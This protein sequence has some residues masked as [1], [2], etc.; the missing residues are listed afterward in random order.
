MDNQIISNP[1]EPPAPVITPDVPDKSLDAGKKKL[2][3]VVKTIESEN[4]ILYDEE[5]LLRL[6]LTLTIHT[7]AATETPCKSVM[8]QVRSIPPRA[9]CE[10]AMEAK[11]GKVVET[12]VASSVSK[13]D[14][15]RFQSDWMDLW[16]PELT[17]L[18]ACG[19]ECDL[20]DS[21]ELLRRKY[22][23]Y[24]VKSRKGSRSRAKSK[25]KSAQV[26]ILPTLTYTRTSK[27]GSKTPRKL[28]LPSRRRSMS[29]NPSRRDSTTTWSQ[30]SMARSMRRRRAMKTPPPRKTKKT[31][32]PR[33]ATKTPPHRK[34]MKTPPPRKSTNTPPPR[35]ATKTPP[36]PKSEKSPSLKSPALKSITIKLAKSKDKTKKKDPKKESIKKAE[37]I[38]KT[39]PTITKKVAGSKDKESESANHGKNCLCCANTPVRLLPKPM[40]ITRTYH[41]I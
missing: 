9:V 17:E 32:P 14:L 29:S 35:K 24:F 16:K 37:S 18:D 21:V 20:A 39:K 3:M 31:P 6:K 41:Y 30:V 23:E 34:S 40:I 13:E 4:S 26:P 11:T 15:P 2:K 8:T 5:D 33:K 36:P 1:D 7:E 25:K 12:F 19:S 28:S 27:Q 38:N 22:Y 10:V